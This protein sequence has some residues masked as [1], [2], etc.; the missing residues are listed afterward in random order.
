MEMKDIIG[1][2]IKL[3]ANSI[4]VKD[5]NGKTRGI[6]RGARRF[7]DCR[8]NQQIEIRGKIKNAGISFINAGVNFDCVINA[9]GKWW[10]I[11]DLKWESDYFKY[12]EGRDESLDKKYQNRRNIYDALVNENVM[13][14]IDCWILR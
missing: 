3:S 10:Y 4:T 1:K 9:E 6:V 13:E 12:F 14:V 2:R 5:E 11:N 8:A 7:K